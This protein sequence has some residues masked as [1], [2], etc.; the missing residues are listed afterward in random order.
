MERID[1]EII[2]EFIQR[3]NKGPLKCPPDFEGD[4]VCVKIGYE[5]DEKEKLND[6]YDCAVYQAWLDLNRTVAGAGSKT[7]H[8]R[9]K[10]A[11][12]D[13]AAALRG[14]FMSEPKQ[15]CEAF[16]EWLYEIISRCD[17][18]DDLTLSQ[19]QKL[20][21][22]AFKY[23][24]CC[25]ELREQ[26]D[27][28]YFAFCH[29]PLDTYTLKWYKDNC[30]EKGE[31]VCKWSQ[32]DDLKAYEHIVKQIRSAVIDMS[33]LEAEF[34]IWRQEKQRAEK[35]ALISSAK[36][37]VNDDDCPD[38]LKTLLEEYIKAK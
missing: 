13:V 12:N 26:E 33:V 32:L 23:L 5:V 20:I 28:L 7:A 8:K 14:Y 4:D 24:Y 15:T 31:K 9:I 11:R 37:I 2:R 36:K 29:M 25:G 34:S 17:P 38:E 3:I 21:N 6:I 30:A 27:G 18:K 1:L 10:Q 16:D 22:M 19:K 35:A